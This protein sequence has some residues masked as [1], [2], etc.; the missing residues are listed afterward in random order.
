MT[1][2]DIKINSG[3]D[4]AVKLR[5]DYFLGLGLKIT[6]CDGYEIRSMSVRVSNDIHAKKLYEGTGNN[7]RF[8]TSFARRKN[9][10][11]QPVGDYI[12]VL[13]CCKDAPNTWLLRLAGRVDW[14]C[15]CFRCVVEWMP[16]LNA[17][18]EMQVK[19]DN[20]QVVS[21]AKATKRLSELGDGLSSIS[22]A[23]YSASEFNEACRLMASAGCP[24]KGV[25]AEVPENID[26][27]K[28]VMASEVDSIKRS[29]ELIEVENAA[30]INSRVDSVSDALKHLGH[31]AK[32]D[33]S[34]TINKLNIAIDA[35]VDITQELNQEN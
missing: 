21:L 34:V 10:G 15:D 22:E 28:A 13:I 27:I 5:L 35:L 6:T 32:S 23:G 20:A 11:F 4:E 1:E 29:R 25:S 12:P 31:S 24:V 26:K 33:K 17:L 2:N 14:E 30:H 9:E 3:Q 16:N 7:E 18:I 19:S 8:I